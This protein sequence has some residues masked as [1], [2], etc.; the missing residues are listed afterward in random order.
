MFKKKVMDNMDEQYIQETEEKFKRGDFNE[1][2]EDDQE[3][4]KQ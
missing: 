2:Y 1:V 3:N 4:C